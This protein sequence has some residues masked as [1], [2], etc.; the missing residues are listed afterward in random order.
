MNTPYRECPRFHKCS[1]NNCPLHP[2]Y[3]NLPVDPEDKEQKC[4]MEKQVRFKIGSNYPE[5]LK[6]KGLTSREWAGK[7]KFDS[8]TPGEKEAIRQKAKIMGKGLKSPLSSACQIQQSK[9]MV[10]EG[11]IQK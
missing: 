10:L 4:T 7:Q 9:V 8:M 2:S 6:W 1:V 3:P 5:V 11:G